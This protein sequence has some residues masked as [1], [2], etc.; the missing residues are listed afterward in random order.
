VSSPSVRRPASLR[1]AASTVAALLS[2][3]CAAPVLPSVAPTTDTGPSP[4][5]AETA[6]VRA[7]ESS[8]SPAAGGIHKIKHVVVVMQENRSFD[9]YFGTFPGANGIPMVNGVPTVCVPDNQTGRCV[10]PYH[11]ADLVDS[12]GPHHFADA[13]GDVDGGKMDGFV[14]QDR[15][16]GD[17]ACAD[18]FDPSCVPGQKPLSVMGYKTEAEIPNYWEYARKFVLQDAMFEPTTSW[19]LPAHL[20]MV[21]DWSARCT[22]VADPMSCYNAPATPDWNRYGT[23][24]NPDYAWTD[25]TWLLH[26]AGVSWAYYVADG[27]EPDCWND[28]ATCTP[29]QQRAG[30][31]GIWNPLPWFDTVRQDGQLQN[32][33]PL[34]SFKDAIAAGNLP[35]VSWVVPNGANSEHPPGSI[36]DGQAYVTDLVNTLMRSGE[37]SST[38]IFVTWDDWG[39]FYDHVAPPMV[40]GNG[41]GLRVPGLV[42]SPYAKRGYIDHQ[43]LSFD[44]Y[45][46]FIEDDFIAGSRIDPAT[47]GRPDPRPDVREALPQLGDLRD[48]FDFAQQPRPP[49]ILSPRPGAVEHPGSTVQPPPTSD[50]LPELLRQVPSDGPIPTGGPYPPPD[51][52]ADE[53]D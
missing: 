34:T 35:A 2:V 47:D 26:A 42:I 7:S 30:T 49:M 11:D 36:A 15:R 22:V 40:D 18:P 16:Y 33:Q 9:Q 53:G 25:I 20:F 41:Y 1:I 38:A 19:S 14:N 48:D 21:S 52:V 13:I 32:I 4:S 51:H 31:P 45:L 3:S 6:G 37:W 50:S 39:G 44:A 23:R 12:G 46:K 5:A 43:T 10:R 27:T 29:R 28:N 17:N 24:P 8:P